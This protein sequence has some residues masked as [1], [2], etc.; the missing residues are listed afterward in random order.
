M[1]KSKRNW[2]D[3]LRPPT[4]ALENSSFGTSQLT[5][6]LF[7]ILPAFLREIMGN[8]WGWECPPCLSRPSSIHVRQ[9][10]R[11][12]YSSPSTRTSLCTDSNV[13]RRFGTR[14]DGASD[15][16]PVSPIMMY[17]NRYAYDMMASV[18]PC[19]IGASCVSL[20][21]LLVSLDFLFKSGAVVCI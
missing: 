17:L 14:S 20:P 10:P 7:A 15:D 9:P 8:G 12:R 5:L 21:P 13:R 4:A 1:R 11:V 3:Y 18:V 6:S 2:D 19:A 16:S